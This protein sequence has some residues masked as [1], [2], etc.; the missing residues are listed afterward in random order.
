[1]TSG[2]KKL[3]LKDEIM[4]LE[5]DIKGKNEEIDLLM[6]EERRWNALITKMNATAS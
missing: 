5:A 6:D 4:N 3:D 1:M 2:S